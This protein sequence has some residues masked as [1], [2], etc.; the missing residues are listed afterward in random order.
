MMAITV[1]T[2]RILAPFKN[3]NE[4]QGHI[5]RG[6]HQREA[7]LCNLKFSGNATFYIY[8]ISQIFDV[9]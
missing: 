9:S 2:V 3:D 8:F 6:R 4:N 7:D 1:A 5:T